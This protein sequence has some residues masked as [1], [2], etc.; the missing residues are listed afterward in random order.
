MSKLPLK[1]ENPAGLHQRYFVE[2]LD[3]EPMDDRAEYFILRLDKF[4]TDPKHISACRKAIL[5]YAD[6]IRDHLPKLADDLIQRYSG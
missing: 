4:G 1:S 5:T 6:E 3:G 2:K